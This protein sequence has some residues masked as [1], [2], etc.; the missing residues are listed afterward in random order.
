MRVTSWNVNGI[1]ACAKKGFADWLANSQNDI[2]G[3]QEVRATEA[4]IP[5]EVRSAAG[6]ATHFV[7][8]ERAGYSGVGLFSRLS[9]DDIE[10][11]LGVDEFDIEGRL[12]IARFGKLSVVNCY[13]PNGNGKER[14]NSRIPYKL[15]FYK[16]LFERLEKPMRDGERVLVIGDFNT[17]HRPIDLARPKQNEE[18]SGFRPEEREELDRWLRAGWVDTFRHFHPE[19]PARYSWWSQRFGAREKNVGWRIDY[20]LASPGAMSFVTGAEIHHDVKGSDHCPVSV[21]VEGGIWA[22]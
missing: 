12:Q 14:D 20:V 15:A 9:P 18:T 4:Q 13:F 11:S 17:A 21:S 16:R 10:T 22:R 8:A 6:F 3:V 5:D 2:V 19:V 1:R 7:A